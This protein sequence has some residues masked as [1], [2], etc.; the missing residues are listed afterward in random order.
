MTVGTRTRIEA[1]KTTW[2][3]ALL[4]I[5]AQACAGGASSTPVGGPELAATSPAPEVAG[6]ATTGPNPQRMYADCRERVEGP[7]TS[8][9]C[10]ADAGCATAGCG[11]E[12]CVSASAAASGISTTCEQRP[13]FQALDRCTCQSGQCTWTVKSSLPALPSNARPIQLPPKD[14][15]GRVIRPA[16][17][18]AAEAPAVEPSP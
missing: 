17:P 7:S 9:E 5:G 16:A 11:G 2:I 3:S 13:C 8:G 1:S 18:P 4:L 12:L 6:A 14:A 15:E 10:T